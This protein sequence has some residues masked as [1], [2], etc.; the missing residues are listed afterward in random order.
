M[1]KQEYIDK[2]RFNFGYHPYHGFSMISCGH[3]ADI[4]CAA[5]YIVGAYEPGYAR[6]MGMKTRATFD[7]A[8]QDAQ[9]YV[10]I[11]PK[12]LALPKTFRTAGVHLTMK[13][14]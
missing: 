12:I 13:T 1:V 7:D 5:I 4:H 14:N 9:K 10:G 3:I 11:S 6:A 8:L 2:Y